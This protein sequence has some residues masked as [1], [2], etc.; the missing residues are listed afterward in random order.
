[1]IT[2]TYTCD[3]CLHIQDNDSGMHYIAINYKDKS[4]GAGT[5]FH[6]KL[7]CSSCCKKFKLYW[8]PPSPTPVLITL[9]D[10]VR[11]MIKE[12]ISNASR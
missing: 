5:N 7:W 2:T 11:E 9:E 3:C 12:E 8:S 10:V 6:E 4:Y 1:M